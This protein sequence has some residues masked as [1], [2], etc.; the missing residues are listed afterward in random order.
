M[1]C[2]TKSELAGTIKFREF[3]RGLGNWTD[4][5]GVVWNVNAIIGKVVCACKNSQLHPYYTDTSSCSS[6]GFVH[7]EWQPYAIEVAS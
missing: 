3:P 7:Q 5:N 1:S 4:V 6:Y 2:F